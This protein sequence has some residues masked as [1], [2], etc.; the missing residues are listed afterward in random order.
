MSLQDEDSNEETLV[1]VD[2]SALARLEQD[3]SGVLKAY[4]EVPCDSPDAL[5][6]WVD[7][8]NHAHGVLKEHEVERTDVTKPINVDLRRINKWFKDGAAS[9]T[10]FK[11]L[12]NEKIEAYELA[13]EAA[14]VAGRLAAQ[15][16][17]AT[18][19]D[20]AVYDALAAIPDQTKTSGNSVRMVWEAEVFEVDLLPEEWTQRVVREDVIATYLK[21]FEGRDTIP[22]MAGIRFKRVAKARPVGSRS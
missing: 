19:D 7:W 2:R 9:L 11:K 10:A 16:A 18:G 1:P 14:A 6:Q 12:A 21:T 20:E 13:Q 8:R 3:W 5:L 17:A 15:V 22:G 4:K